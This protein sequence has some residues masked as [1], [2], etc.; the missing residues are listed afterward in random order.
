MG[1]DKAGSLG[2]Q[3]GFTLIEIALVLVVLVVM[4]AMTI[5]F[6]GNMTGMKASATARKLQSDIAY[7]QALAMTRNLRHRVYVNGSPAPVPDGYAVV[8]DMDADGNWGEPGEF[9][10]DPVAGG[11][12]SVTLNAGDYAG[13][14]ITAVGFAGSYVEFNGLGVPS[15]GAG[16]LAG[17][18]SVTVSGG[19]T[20]HTV[21]VEPQTGQTHSP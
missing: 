7:A 16:L 13:I 6:L 5:N 18:T 15:S 21:T 3:R 2:N 12:L 4:T 8:N 1:P 19:G 10:G 20:L 14:T 9:A 11:N 17:A